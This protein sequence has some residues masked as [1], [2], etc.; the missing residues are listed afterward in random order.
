MG[1][2]NVGHPFVWVFIFE[3]TNCPRFEFP[4]RGQFINDEKEKTFL[5]RE[6]LD[7][8]L[9]QLSGKVSVL[10]YIENVYLVVIVG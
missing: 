9:V 7:F 10:A 3:D 2:P 6:S 8:R 4:H 1:L 5:N